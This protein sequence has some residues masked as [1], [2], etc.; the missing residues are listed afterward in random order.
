MKKKVLDGFDALYANDSAYLNTTLTNFTE[1]SVNVNVIINFRPDTTAQ[2]AQ[3]KITM[4]ITAVNQN[5]IV[6]ITTIPNSSNVVL[7]TN[8]VWSPWSDVT[9]KLFLIIL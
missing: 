2:S 8:G 9:G 4:I 5:T 3:A 7:V 1:G 6:G